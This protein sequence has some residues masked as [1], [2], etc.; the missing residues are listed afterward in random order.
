MSASSKP[1]GLRERR[2]P[3]RA[4]A[5]SRSSS[6]VELILR[7]WRPGLNKV[8]LTQA[9]REGGRP[10]NEA[11]D[12][13]GRVLEGEEVRARFEQFTTIAAARKA[14]TKIGIETVSAG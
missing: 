13:T 12:L 9:F 10:L 14:L 5:R 3:Y 8:R 11:V 1:K 7:G 6:G 2:A 4:G